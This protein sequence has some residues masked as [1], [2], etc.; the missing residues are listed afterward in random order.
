MTVG[1]TVRTDGSAAADAGTRPSRDARIVLQNSEARHSEGELSYPG[2]DVDRLQQRIHR[3]H[4]D[5]R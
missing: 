4:R 5:H 1:T 3:D 2:A